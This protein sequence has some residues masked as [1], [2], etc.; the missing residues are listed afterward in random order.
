MQIGDKID[1]NVVLGI[2]KEK[3]EISLGMKQTQ[4]NPW[5]QVARRSTRPAP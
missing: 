5:D 2:N 4:S 3:Q 1:V